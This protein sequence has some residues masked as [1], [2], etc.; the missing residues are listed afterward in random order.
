MTLTRRD[1]TLIVASWTALGL[2]E[3]VE[4][5]LELS[6]AGISALSACRAAGS[7]PVDTPR[8]RG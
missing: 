8:D 7:Y 1:Q 5:H 6:G 3:T 2:L 4:G